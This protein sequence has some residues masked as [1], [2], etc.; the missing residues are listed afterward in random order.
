MSLG[1]CSVFLFCSRIVQLRGEGGERGYR[2]KNNGPNL[3]VSSWH[4]VDPAAD[5][6]VFN[7]ARGAGCGKAG[8]GMEWAIFQSSLSPGLALST[9]GKRLVAHGR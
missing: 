6:I 2:M 7:N 4:F 3:Y 9:V 1:H 5:C 8:S